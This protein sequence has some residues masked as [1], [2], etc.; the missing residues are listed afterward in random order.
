MCVHWYRYYTGD[1]KYSGLSWGPG[2]CSH[3]AAQVSINQSINQ[4]IN[5]LPT[6]AASM[7]GCAAQVHAA[8]S[9]QASPAVT[10]PLWHPHHLPPC[11]RNAGSV[12]HTGGAVPPAAASCLLSA[13]EGSHN[14]DVHR[15]QLCLWGVQSPHPG[16]PVCSGAV[17]EAHVT[18]P[19]TGRASPLSY[20]KHSASR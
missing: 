17:H 6:A 10:K 9:L 14:R 15:N 19:V 13:G 18:V 8:P 20:T 12:S 4:S 11:G 3:N 2:V 1:T 7:C 5:S 16:Y